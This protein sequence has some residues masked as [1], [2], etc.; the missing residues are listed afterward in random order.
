MFKNF[1]V[2]PL[3]GAIAI[4]CASTTTLAEQSNSQ[5]IVKL[6][7]I[8]VTATRSAQSLNTVAARVHVIDENTLAQS[9]IAS[10]PDLLQAEAAIN[11]VQLG[12]YGQ[13]AS[14]FTRGA[15]SDQ[16]LVLRDGVR[17]NSTS[18]GIASLGFIDTTDIKQIE[19]LKGPASVLY[20][21]DAIGGVVQLVSKTPE[22]S[23]GFLTGEYGENNTY[24]AIIGADLA[25]N[26]FYAQ[27]RG[28]R[29][30]TDGTA[31][32]EIDNAPTAAFDQRGFSAKFGVEREQY[33]S[34]IDYSDNQ[35]NSQYDS[36]GN[37]TAQD[38]DN[39]MINLK[40]RVNLGQVEVNARL[41]QFEDNIEQKDPNWAGSYDFVHSTSQEAELYGKWDFT[42]TQNLLIGATHRNSEADV[43]S[44]GSPIDESVDTTGYY[45][46]HQFSGQKLNTQVG[47]R[48]EDNEKYGEH[49][50]AQG[51][52]R[53]HFTPATS[54]YSNIGS[55]FRAPS[56]NDL[57][58]YG[59]N[60][61][62]EPEESLS[63]EI[64][65]DHKIA[66]S[67]QTGISLYRT[68]VDNLIDS[69]CIADCSGFGVYQNQNINQATM[70]GGEVY[71]KWQGKNLF[72]NIA[73][74]YVR[75]TDD[76]TGEDLSRRPR[77]S[78]SLTAGWADE[79]YGISST[80]TANDESDNSAFDAVRI[81]GRLRIDLH[82]Y[83]NV[84]D[85]LKLFTNVQ[86][87]GDSKYRTAY[88]SGS[89][90]INGGRLASIGATLRY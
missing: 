63:Y 88:G 33:A 46:Q 21:T 29:L 2:A 86:N 28:Q 25:E 1:P 72:A 26:G 37:M 7:P 68:E 5:D 30:E 85:H 84:N 76:N 40:G 50:V 87:V 61:E 24:K 75:T 80:L 65:L 15:E 8:V 81:P 41:S 20:G 12:G 31:V 9:P 49:T 74:H 45:L 44:Y 16:T 62:L 60:P 19:I 11:M 23:G 53:Y 13:Q 36:M 69:V 35:G 47:V 17:L 89:Y 59:G 38:F 14:I 51:A 56:I 34:S 64:G 79:M 78:A 48:V 73:Y 43:I 77:Q 83:A 22:K 32:K 67:V 52:I 70:E 71:A 55:A 10:L 54:I 57:Y 82:A 39:E 18:A 58:A 6:D 4:A 66:Q 3:V 27:V 90:Y 42:T